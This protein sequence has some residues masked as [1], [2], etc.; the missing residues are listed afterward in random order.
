MGKI[1][2]K[3][4]SNH[5]KNSMEKMYSISPTVASLWRSFFE[6]FASCCCQKVKKTPSVFHVSRPLGT[7]SKRSKIAR[8]LPCGFGHSEGPSTPPPHCI[9]GLLPV[10]VLRKSMDGFCA[11]FPRHFRLDIYIYIIYIYIYINLK[12][13]HRRL[14]FD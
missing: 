2:E 11:R 5:G 8:I 1:H 10:P 9:K 7:L 12:E 14:F 6:P 3:I 4:V 13:S